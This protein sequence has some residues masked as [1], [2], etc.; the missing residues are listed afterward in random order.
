[1]QELK[2]P[3]L[4]E[5]LTKDNILAKDMKKAIILFSLLTLTIC[6]ITSYATNYYVATNGSDANAGTS[7]GAPFLTIAK[8]VSKATVAGDSII[9]RSGTYKVT[10]T[11][12]ITKAG[13]AAKH[14]VLTGYPPDIIAAYPADARPLFDFSTMTVSSGN[15]GFQ[16][17]N[18]NYWY[19]YGIKIKG[20]GDNGMNVNSTSYT[21][22]EYCDFY[23][24]RDAGYLIRNSSHHC[25]VLNCDAYEN[26]D[27]GTGTT[28]SGGN[29]D[30]FAP[31]LEPG[32]SITFR[33]CRAWLNS[34]DGWDGYLKATEAGVPD[35]MTTILENCWTWRN[36]YYWLDGTTTSS[37]N[38]NG[39]KMGG[40]ANKDQAHNFVLVKC[41]S[42]D[43]KGKGFDQNNN[44]G[45]ISLY[46]CTSYNN[47]DYDYGLNSSGVTY[48]ADSIFTVE[49]CTSLG[50]KGTTFK[51]GTVQ[52]TNNFIKATTSPNFLSLDTTGISGIRKIDGSL[53]DVN[54]MHLQT[55]PK[56][57]LIDAGTILSTINY[58]GVKGVPFIHT[59]PDI[60]CFESNYGLPVSLLSF[61][62]SL[63]DAHT[64]KLGWIAAIEQNNKGWDVER[65]QLNGSNNEWS[66]IGNVEGKLNSNLESKYSFN[67]YTIVEGG[68]YAY[69]LKQIDLNG[70]TVYSNIVT[71]NLNH[72]K[73][74][75][76]KS[77]PN[78]A[79]SNTT[80]QFSVAHKTAVSITVYSIGGAPVKQV[81]N[82]MLEAGVYNRSLS[83]SN[84]AKGNYII[85]L[86]SVDGTMAY[87][88][89]NVL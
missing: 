89:I 4:N 5:S 67:D 41:L 37:M 82:E 29:A 70:A 45:S 81:L 76:I 46:N 39:F 65:M 28:T 11:V 44:A 55:T 17:T 64:V 49:N 78:P 50:A 8:A 63:I 56:S 32:D 22:V 13:T 73:T 43:N 54:F 12:K 36:G 71:I 24:N 31:K 84:L 66:T 79:K 87:T 10:A 83:L 35:G 42:F 58:Y 33:G 85:R 21:T 75:E 23:R 19:I 48:S 86:I 69:R 25:L 1:M 18:A 72:I 6:T 57:A 16:L 88:N 52:L 68:T 40:S 2:H 38:G 80:I 3:K 26:A 30:G 77:F 7:I 74:M 60:G 53:P 62:A 61:D 9:V 14:I 27:L 15:Y 59:K 20:A 34:D 51:K 47:I